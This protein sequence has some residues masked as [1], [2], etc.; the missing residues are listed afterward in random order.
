MKTCFLKR[1]LAG[2]ALALIFAG[3][4]AA[5]NAAVETVVV[6]G[7]RIPRPETD[8]P[9]PVATVGSEQIE[10]SGLTNLS[11]VL[12][13]IPAL[14]GSLGDYQTAG[15]NTPA[16]ADGS[17]LGGL[18][19]LDLRNLGYVRTLVL[20]DGHR[21]VSESTGSSAVDVASIPI[22]LIDR[23]EVVTGGSSAVYGADGVSGVVNFVMKHDLD[24]VYARAQYGTSEDGGGSKDLGALAVGHNFDDDKGN[25]TLA[26]EAGHQS[27]LFFTQRD[28]TSVGGEAFFVPNPA[29][30]DGSIP[31]LPA[32]IPTRDV[33]F[34]YSAPTGAIDIQLPRP[35]GK[36]KFDGFP[37]HLGNGGDFIPGID[38]GNGS[39]IGSSGMPYANDLQ[40]DFQP[41]EN[42][43][44]VQFM[45]NYQFSPW[46]R[47]YG[48]FKYSHVDTQSLNIAPFDDDIMI[49]AQNPFLPPALAS[50]IAA[51]PLGE[52]ALSEDYLAMR[53]S[54]RVQRDT[55]RGVADASG[56]LPSPGFLQNFRYD[57]SYVNGSTDIDDVN[58][59]NRNI[60]RFA[61]AL[62]SVI[63]PAT[64]KPTCRSNLDPSATPPT[65]NDYA[66]FYG[67]DAN[68]FSDTSSL[69]SA[70]DFGLTFTPGPNSG[71]VPFNPF[72]PHFN[73][74]ASIAWMTQNTHTRGNVSEEVLSGF[75]SAD[76]QQFQD[77]G[78]AKPL[79]VVMGGEYRTESS[80]ST[81]DAITEV[82]GL[83]WFGGTLPVSGSFHVLEA[84]GEMSLPILSDRP[85]AKELTFDAAGRLSKYS[86][87]GT[88][89]SWKL[90]LVYSPIEG[91]KFRGTDAV[92]VRAPN[93]GEL[94][95]P[96]QN[97]FSFINDPCDFHFIGQG[98]SFRAANCQAIEDAVL[99]PGKYVAGETSTQT[100]QTTPTSVSGNPLLAP[101]TARTLTFGIV[102][103]PTFI[104]N[105]V[106]TVDWY[107]VKIFD[108]IQAPSGQSV[109]NECV[110]LST[111]NNPFCTNVQR[112]PTGRFPGSISLVNTTQINVAVY[113]TQGID[114]T[115]DYHLDL[116]DW[117][118]EKFGTLDFHLIGNHLDTLK[119]TP[120]PGEQPVKSENLLYGGADALTPTPYWSFNLDTVWHL[121]PWTVDYNVDW[122]NGVLIS[123]DRQTVKAEPNYVLHKYLHTD[124]RN[125]HSVQVA[126]DASDSVQLYAGVQNLWY[127]KPSLGQNGYPVNPLG[128][129]FY[130]GIRVNMDRIPGL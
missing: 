31:N 129:F 64:G 102:L 44:I 29:N 52:A 63:D 96:K 120:L 58:L 77:W 118:N 109:A 55:Y 32:N 2:S 1:L 95:A 68:Y 3:E 112:T 57:V 56:E 100:D 17:S 110:D 22:T 98:T 4:S 126:Y 70:S 73:N 16:A 46:L 24:G 65:L 48:E 103:Q 30:P 90:G 37:D 33:Q 69:F 27:H 105:F 81:P 101:E 50:L 74:A 39:A 41:T 62:D 124:A 60:D 92:A 108:A 8:L 113:S 12:Q 89:Q 125:F 34:I 99:G 78:F 67:K 25:V 47:L 49:T 66:N 128:R 42:R 84:F 15:Y 76:V 51:S 54:E 11:D 59:R 106:A 111:I 14:T 87:A 82:P 97:L 7:T 91:L 104:P 5:Q 6:T 9:N 43:R 10:N 79:S 61:A 13:R 94:F 75:V 53:E 80:R 116:E 114:F 26:I 36:V 21:M 40:G 119:T 130:G 38:I 19:L 93:I 86:T 23:V 122:Y 85:F 18:N 28:F 88:N 107:R 20:V 115:A 72:D 71:C 35:N 117:F 127:Q 83:Y 45:A 121:A 123:P